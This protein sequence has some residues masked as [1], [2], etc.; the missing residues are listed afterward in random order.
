MPFSLH[1]EHWRGRTVV[2]GIP[3]SYR[4][5]FAELEADWHTR[6]ADDELNIDVRDGDESF[7]ARYGDIH[8]IRLVG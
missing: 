3:E 4:A 8:S 7:T 5:D 1:I 2:A 6:P